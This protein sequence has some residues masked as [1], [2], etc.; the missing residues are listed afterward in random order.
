[1]GFALGWVLDY[2]DSLLTHHVGTF[3]GDLSPTPV[4]GLQLVAGTRNL[5][6][7]EIYQFFKHSQPCL[8]RVFFRNAKQRL[9]S[10]IKGADCVGIGQGISTTFEGVRNSGTYHRAG[11]QTECAYI[12]IL[13]ILK[14]WASLLVLLVIL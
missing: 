14:G 9:I 10:A 11:F 1:M 3:L 2:Q 12:A 5:P 7:M 4:L 13:L 8:A 6:P